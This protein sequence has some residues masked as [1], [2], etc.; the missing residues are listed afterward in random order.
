MRERVDARASTTRTNHWRDDANDCAKNRN[1]A[2]VD[3][4]RS[5]CAA[6]VFVNFD[7][8]RSMRRIEVIAQHR[9]R[10]KGSRADSES[11]ILATKKFS[12]L[13]GFA[14]H[15]RSPKPDFCANRAS[16][17]RQPHASC[18]RDASTFMVNDR[19]TRAASAVASERIAVP[20]ARRR[21]SDAELGL[22][23]IVHG[24]RIGLAAGRLHHLADEPA[25]QL[26]AWLSPARPCRDWRR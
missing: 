6:V 26:P 5:D 15:R 23:Q 22:Q 3:V 17:I 14:P 16:P 7:I 24:L 18:A 9:C 19:C 8:R 11:R 1:R 10:S 4:A 25:D 21:D 13:T 12:R 20:V 2:I